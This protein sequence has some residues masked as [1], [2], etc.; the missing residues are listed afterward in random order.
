MNNAI[1][2]LSSRHLQLRTKRW[3]H[4]TSSSNYWNINNYPTVF[5]SNYWNL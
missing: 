2:R 1:E 3:L 5:W 4:K